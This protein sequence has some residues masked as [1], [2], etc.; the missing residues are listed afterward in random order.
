[1]TLFKNLVRSLR[2]GALGGILLATGGCDYILPDSKS[3][4]QDTGTA[5]TSPDTAS[6]STSPPSGSLDNKVEKY[7]VEERVERSG[8]VL[9]TDAEA[10][11][12]PNE[13]GTE[14]VNSIF[15]EGKQSAIAVA[16]QASARIKSKILDF[17]EMILPVTTTEQRDA[18]RRSLHEQGIETF[19]SPIFEL[20]EHLDVERAEQA[21]TNIWAYRR[22]QLPEALHA[23]GRTDF[24]Y[25]PAVAVIDTG[26]KSD[27]LN[28]VGGY[29][30][31][32]IDGNYAPSFLCKNNDHGTKVAGI[33]GARQNRRG[34]N[35][36]APNI[37]LYG[38]KVQDFHRHCFDDTNISGPAVIASLKEIAERPD[39]RVLNLSI[40]FG[41]EE[42][43]NEVFRRFMKR[44]LDS[45]K[46]VVAG[47]GNY[48][49][50]AGSLFTVFPNIVGVGGTQLN[51]DGTE[52]RYLIDAQHG[53]NY[54]ERG[55]R[56]LAA[57]ARDV[58]VVIEDYSTGVGGGTSF[59][60][61]MVSGLAALLR[62]RGRNA[63]DAYNIMH[64]TADQLLVSYPD[65]SQALWHRINAYRAVC[66][67]VSCGEQAGGVIDAPPENA[68]NADAGRNNGHDAGA[69]RD[70][71]IPGEDVG[72][73]GEGEG[74]GAQGGGE[75]QRYH[76]Y[77]IAF[78]ANNRFSQVFSVQTRADC[79]I[80]DLTQLTDSNHFK[81]Q[82]RTHLNGFFYVDHQRNGGD[83]PFYLY[84]DGEIIHLGSAHE[85]AASPVDSRIV[86]DSLHDEMLRIA[87]PGEEPS[88][89]VPPRVGID[90]SEATFHHFQWGPTG[91]A[92]A[93]GFSYW[94]RGTG[95]MIVPT[96][97]FDSFFLY[98]AASNQ[99]TIGDP[100]WRDEQNFLYPCSDRHGEE[101]K[102]ICLFN[103]A[104][105]QEQ[106]PYTFPD[107]SHI[108]S[109]FHASDGTIAMVRSPAFELIENAEVHRI[110][111]RIEISGPY[112]LANLDKHQNPFSPDSR[113]LAYYGRPDGIDVSGLYLYDRQTEQHC[114]LMGNG[115][116][117]VWKNSADE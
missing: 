104:S 18:I 116:E 108:Y 69:E 107:G 22:I 65:N 63:E 78:P 89:I 103:T 70:A 113:L 34:L 32:D 45:G 7:F 83:N 13:K 56:W 115:T 62:S 60:T 75:E 97:D 59:S 6:S 21:G 79:H 33:I 94:R 1:M 55:G 28:I 31:A 95:F 49:E 77:T 23:L 12:E 38:Y 14:Y 39:I 53:S 66:S 41:D 98:D 92:L 24:S 86:W 99:R 73:I 46:L 8:M 10:E 96:D 44:V 106:E 26:F 72:R 105:L 117:A 15:V 9:G 64:A 112:N 76:I 4:V 58:A 114:L 52:E 85:F 43:N 101:I 16:E 5:D 36:V 80:E 100:I 25:A 82:L 47:S 51:A 71:G 102:N 84:R 81:A 17:Y 68:G 61:P 74:E 19:T 40:K 42:V 27:E 67:V 57:P 35:G 3:D 54:W 37:P 30:Y 48:N 110:N 11:R 91:E 29:D 93:I 88:V 87:V 111:H 90:R 20:N 2:T 109:L 50:T